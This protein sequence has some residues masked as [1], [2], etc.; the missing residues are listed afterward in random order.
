MKPTDAMLVWL[1]A[2]PLEELTS[3]RSAHLV[4]QYRQGEITLSHALPE[5]WKLC[6][7][8][9]SEWVQ[10]NFELEHVDKILTTDENL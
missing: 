1:D 8:E 10:F 3:K 2:I 7:R 6:G 9:L 4:K 5:L